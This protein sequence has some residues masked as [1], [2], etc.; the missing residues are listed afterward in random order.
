MPNY[1]NNPYMQ[2]PY[3]MYNGQPQN[4]QQQFYNQPQPTMQQPM[5]Q[6]VQQVQNN[7][8][9]LTLVETL[10]DVKTYLV[11]PNQVVYLKLRNN[12]TIFEKS[13]N[14]QG[15][16]TINEYRKF[17]NSTP[18]ENVEYAYA[19]DLTALETTF[20]E[21]LNKLSTQLENLSKN[22]NRTQKGGNR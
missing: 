7:Y 2:Y 14:N 6:Q 3:S 4:V 16:Y 5:Q 1:Y 19:K 8:L 15:E 13:A 21:R 18:K 20:N 9:P 22:G 10:D 17:D 11:Q 12:N